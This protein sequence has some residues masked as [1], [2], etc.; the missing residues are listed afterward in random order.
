V[1]EEETAAIHKG[2]QNR[3]VPLAGRIGKA[4]N[5]PG[6]LMD[7]PPK[8]KRRLC[9]T[10]LSSTQLATAYR[11]LSVLQAPFGFVFWLIEQHKAKLQDCIENERQCDK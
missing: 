11:V 10:A 1:D 2:W 6:E 9:G 8:R 3:A 4:P 7:S 5:L